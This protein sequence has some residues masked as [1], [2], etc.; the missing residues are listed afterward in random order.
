[1]I[2][3]TYSQK[4]LDEE[5][6]S[7]AIIENVR[8]FLDAGANVNAEN[9][10]KQTPLHLAAY[11]GHTEAA[12]LILDAGADVDAE[13]KYKWTPLHMA[14]SRGRTEVARLLLDRGAQV[15][16]VNMYKQTPL[17]LAAISGHTEVA[18]LLILNGADPFKAFDG[19]D[20]IIEFFKGDIS[21]MPEEL[22]AKLERRVRSR[23]AFG[24]F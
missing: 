22:K 20:S 1:M 18:R 19:L 4:A 3:D 2:V 23:G 14:A 6:L 10:N 7:A 17:Y 21:W 24:R 5:L 15:D 13:D 12:K 9:D 8:L 11:H 16:A